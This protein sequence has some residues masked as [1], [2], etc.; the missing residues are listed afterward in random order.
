M[1]ELARHSQREFGDWAETQ[2]L[3]SLRECYP[4]YLWQNLNVEHNNAPFDIV[5]CWPTSGE[6]V[7]LVE[8]KGTD[9]TGNSPGITMRKAAKAR[10][11]NYVQDTGGRPVMA[12][13]DWQTGQIVLRTGIANF[14]VVEMQPIDQA[15]P[16]VFQ[17]GSQ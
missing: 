14:H 3:H 16:E 7:W 12:C 13:Y 17:E 8:V 6:V 9:F 1:A 10:K 11:L 15:L 5:G 4:Q 2:V